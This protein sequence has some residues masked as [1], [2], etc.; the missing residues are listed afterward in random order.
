M[1][2][3]IAYETVQSPSGT[4]SPRYPMSEVAGMPAFGGGERRENRI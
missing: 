2:T 1:V 4:L 3:G